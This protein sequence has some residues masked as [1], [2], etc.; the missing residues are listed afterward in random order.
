MKKK[1]NKIK[2]RPAKNY[3][4]VCL[5]IALVLRKM[6][7]EEKEREEEKMNR[8]DILDE[9]FAFMIK[10]LDEALKNYFVEFPQ[11]EELKK[12]T[13]EKNI[14]DLKVIRDLI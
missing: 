5:G 6:E 13:K 7:R 3:A 4:I 14:N 10:H 2:I 12:K 11:R 1:W 9:I 8:K